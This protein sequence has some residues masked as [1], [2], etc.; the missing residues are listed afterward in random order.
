LLQ[1]AIKKSYVI[2][3]S[4]SVLSNAFILVVLMGYAGLVGFS[5]LFLNF[6][7]FAAIFK[8][9]ENDEA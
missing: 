2:N 6:A 8:C 4:I 9:R 3:Y 7:I 5:L 1:F